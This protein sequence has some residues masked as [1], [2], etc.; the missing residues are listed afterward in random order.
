MTDH[1]NYIRSNLTAGFFYES[2]QLLPGTGTD[3]DVLLSNLPTPPYG[4]SSWGACSNSEFSRAF[5]LKK[6]F[7]NS[8]LAKTRE[9]CR[10]AFKQ[11]KFL[12]L[13]SL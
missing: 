5:R 10:L 4:I 3:D 9:S 11:F 6:G 7:S 8:F 13:P 12:T 2:I 1:I